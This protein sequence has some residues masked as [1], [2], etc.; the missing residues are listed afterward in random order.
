[1]WLTHVRTNINAKFH[2][3]SSTEYFFSQF[4]IALERKSKSGRNTNFI[5]VFKKHSADNREDELVMTSVEFWKKTHHMSHFRKIVIYLFL[6]KFYRTWW[7]FN[8]I[9]RRDQKSFLLYHSCTSFN[10]DWIV[11]NPNFWNRLQLITIESTEQIFILKVKST[12][13]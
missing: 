8:S 13:E 12:V 10:S 3:F 6:A 4:Y 1:M 9:I 2:C 7:K 11:S 5:P